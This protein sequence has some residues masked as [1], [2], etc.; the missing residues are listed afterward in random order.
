MSLHIKGMGR[1]Q[2]LDKTVLETII[3]M[4]PDEKKAVITKT[5]P[6]INQAI[7]IRDNS[8]LTPRQS[9]LLK[10]LYN[11]IIK[12]KNEAHYNSLNLHFLRDYINELKPINDTD[13]DT[14]ETLSEKLNNSMSPQN[15]S[16]QA[17]GRRSRSR[18]RSRRR[19]VTRK[20]RIR[21]NY[22]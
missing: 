5:I 14:I 2:T 16:G 8:T 3:S 22:N 13:Y 7:S 1:I 21:R 11:L 15:I 10:T 19:R 12:F 17:A 9:I 4:V 18:S 20:P 6:V